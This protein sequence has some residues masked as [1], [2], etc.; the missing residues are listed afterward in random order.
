MA[1][2]ELDGWEYTGIEPR[3]GLSYVCSA[4]V[5]AFLKEA[6]LFGTNE[7]NAVE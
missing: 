3:D 4:Y 2:P 7:I 5:V 6:G 1:M